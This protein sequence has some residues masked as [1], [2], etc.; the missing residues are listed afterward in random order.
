MSIRRFKSARAI[1][2]EDL[3]DVRKDVSTCGILLVPSRCL[4][5]FAFNNIVY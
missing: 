5:F 1:D 4:G 2:M 3:N